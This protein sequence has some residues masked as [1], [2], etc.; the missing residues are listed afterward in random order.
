MFKR[1]GEMEKEVDFKHQKCGFCKYFLPWGNY[2][3]G[4]S[5]AEVET[6]KC[7]RYPPKVDFRFYPYFEKHLMSVLGYVAEA[8]E[9]NEISDKTNIDSETHSEKVIKT[10]SILP[11]VQMDGFCGEYKPSDISQIKEIINLF[12]TYNIP[13]DKFQDWL[14]YFEKL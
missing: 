3:E 13:T 7:R 10:C 9:Q 1:I 11:Y 2:E 14:N 5:S 4:A 8:L 6:G 12:E